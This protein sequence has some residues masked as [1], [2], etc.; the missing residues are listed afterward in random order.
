MGEE[1]E[2]FDLNGNPLGAEDRK[3]FYSEIKA[4]FNTKGKISS[5]RTSVF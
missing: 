1:L 4:E 2:I 3:K 5:K